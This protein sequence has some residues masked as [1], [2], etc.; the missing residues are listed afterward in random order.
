M[1]L[2]D[3]GSSA[4]P[5]KDACTVCS[6]SGEVRQLSEDKP[7]MHQVNPPKLG[8]K[9]VRCGACDGTGKAPK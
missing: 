9:M 2:E 7:T 4:D 3:F 6:G 8:A 5:F 1:T